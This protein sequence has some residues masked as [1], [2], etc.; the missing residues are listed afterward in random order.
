MKPLLLAAAAFLLTATLAGA[1]ALSLQGA[2]DRA[3]KVN[4]T[5]QTALLAVDQAAAARTDVVNW[6]GIAVSATQKQTSGSETADAVT[7]NSVG[8]ALPLFDQLSASASVDQEKTA[9]LSVTAT[10]LA[11]SATAEQGRIAY[12]KAV[13]AAALARNTLE[14]AVRKAWLAQASAQ[15]Q[16]DVQ[17][18]QTALLETVYRDQKA[19]YEKNEVT[20]AEVRSALKDWTDARTTQTTLD[21]TL[22]KAKAALGALIQTEAAELAP[23]DWSAVQALVEALGPIDPTVTG[24]STSVKVQTLE[25]ANQKAQAEATWWLDPTLAV[26]ASAVV[27]DDGE[28]TWTG[29]VTLTLALG[30]WQGTERSLADRA[31]ALAEASLSAEK[32]AARATEAQALLAVQAAADTVESRVIALTQAQELLKET[33]LLSKAGEATDVELEDAGLGVESAGNDLFSAWVDAYSARLD[34]AAARS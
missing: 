32:T 16:R 20:L 24:A 19:M 5:Y 21:R 22:V 2:V 15:A 27:P 14:T 33:Q 34:L 18:K 23:L 13:L 12:E 3:L 6:K 9:T 4:V 31:V 28:L 8:L 7:T 11:H 17:V 30:D 10:P 25:V 29:S 1:E 26:N